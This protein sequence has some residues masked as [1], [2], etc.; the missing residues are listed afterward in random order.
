M[1][2]RAAVREYFPLPMI[3]R[4]SGSSASGLPPIASLQVPYNRAFERTE[5]LS[6]VR[7]W[8]LADIASTRRSVRYRGKADIEQATFN[9]AD[10]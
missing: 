5:K 8:P 1:M 2:D 3:A 7:F 9:K 4:M 10:L 6:D